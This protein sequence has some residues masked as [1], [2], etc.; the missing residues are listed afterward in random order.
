[1]LVFHPKVRPDVVMFET[2]SGVVK[3]MVLALMM[4]ALSRSR[5]WYPDVALVYEN[6]EQIPTMVTA[7]AG[8]IW[9]TRFELVFTRT[10]HVSLPAVTL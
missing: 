3:D 2:V 5:N 10:W 8:M 1:M 9:P 6:C 7:E 4:S